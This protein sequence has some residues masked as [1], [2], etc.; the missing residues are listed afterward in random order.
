MLSALDVHTIK[1]VVDKCLSGSLLRGRTI[2]LVT[3]NLALVGPLARTIVTLSSSGLASITEAT[4]SAI[5]ENTSVA[6]IQSET[7]KEVLDQIDES[8][9]IEAHRVGP[10][11]GKLVAD[12]EVALGH[13]SLSAS[14]HNF[15][16][17]ILA[18]SLTHSL[19]PSVVMMYLRSMGGVWFWTILLVTTGLIDVVDL[20]EV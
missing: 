10:S 14:E 15:D 4:K 2:I 8:N 5:V 6:D 12:E 18:R 11:K 20:C 9:P 13:V 16:L 19:A 7:E 1:W 17:T 3:H